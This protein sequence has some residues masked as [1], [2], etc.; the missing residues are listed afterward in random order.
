ML[1]MLPAMLAGL[2]VLTGSEVPQEAGPVDGPYTMGLVYGSYDPVYLTGGITYQNFAQIFGEQMKELSSEE[3]FELI[4]QQAGYASPAICS[5]VQAMI[6]RGVDAILLDMEV[7]A[8]CTRGVLDAQNAGVPI[9]YFGV[10]PPEPLSCPVIGYNN[11]EGSRRLGAGMARYFK[12][13][14]GGAKPHILVS[15]T[16]SD[17]D[18]VTLEQGF[19]DGFTSVIPEASLDERAEDLGT[20]RD[21]SRVVSALLLGNPDI[22]VIF[23]TSDL[24]AQ[25]ALNALVDLG[26]SESGDVLL[27]GVGGSQ[28]AL[29]ELMNPDSPWIAEIALPL[30]KAAIRSHRVLRDMIEG[31]M[32]IT[33]DSEHLVMPRVFIDSDAAEIRE[34]LNTQRGVEQP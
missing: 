29:R 28:D 13:E 5:A 15:S 18:N 7:P 24:R 25:G 31:D 10:R 23:A 26:R 12:R 14:F 11:Y 32:E 20:V 34:Y 30:E 33:N 16:R 4:T 6:G 19:M 3:G 1:V 22:N 9:A 21:S 17:P 27:A 8:M 2:V